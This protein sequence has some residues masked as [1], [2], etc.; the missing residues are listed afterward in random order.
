[1]EPT[2]DL[3]IVPEEQLLQATNTTFPDYDLIPP[4]KRK[5][6]QEKYG[7]I[8]LIL[9]YVS[10]GV[11][12]NRAIELCA[13]TFGL[14]KAT[15]RNRLYNYLAFQDIRIFL[16]SVKETKKELSA[17]EK[18][19]RWALNKYYYNAIKLPL[20]ETYRRLLKDRYCDDTGKVLSTAPTFRQFSYFYQKTVFHFTRS[21]YQ[22]RNDL[23]PS[24]QAPDNN[25][26]YL[27]SFGQQC[28]YQ[29]RRPTC[30]R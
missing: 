16:P 27:I 4:D 8:S 26:R 9:P 20:I 2:D 29:P 15:I 30:Y 23:L 22:I 18:N 3:E 10:N 25:R 12:R 14:S 11:E 5:L 6:I 21:R 7:T 1:M 28:T 24:K 17:D 13:K 19:F